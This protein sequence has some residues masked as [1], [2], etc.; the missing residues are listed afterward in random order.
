[1]TAFEKIALRQYLEENWND[2]LN[3]LVSLGL[4]DSDADRIIKELDDHD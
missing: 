1:M 2:F 4:D 3:H